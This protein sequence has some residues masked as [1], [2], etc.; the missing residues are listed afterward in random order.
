MMTEL[1][2]YALE[3]VRHGSEFV[4]YRGLSASEPRHILVVALASESPAPESIRRLEH[5][6]ELRN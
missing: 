4:L 1:S 2:K 3:R 6:Y 5:E